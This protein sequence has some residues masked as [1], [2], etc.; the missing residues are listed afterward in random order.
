MTDARLIGID[1]GTTSFRGALMDAGGR[2]LDRIEDRIGLTAIQDRAFE[3][4]L[5]AAISPWSGDARLPVIASGMVTSRTGWVETPYLPCP[6]G[7]DELAGALTAITTSA[8]RHLSFVTG[9]SFR[10]ADGAPDV[11][12]GEETQ[13]AGIAR[14]GEQLLVLPGTHSKWAHVSDGRILGFRTAM[15]GDAF[16]ALKDHTVL[17]LTTGSSGGDGQAAFAAGVRTGFA[18][19][20]AGLLGRLFRLRAGALLGDYPAEETAERLSGLLIGTEIA[21]AHRFAP[22]LAAPVVIVGGAELATRY[23]AAFAALG[24]AAEAADPD[25]AFHGQFRIARQAGLV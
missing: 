18:E 9:M 10:H 5:E 4:A 3:A 19:G 23:A 17:R 2:I 15:T 20:G 8:G 14:P 22:G 21:E 6:A 24:M 16:A 7:A 25:A 12:R 13:I 1:W 11:M